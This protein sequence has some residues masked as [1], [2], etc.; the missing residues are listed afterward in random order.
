[1]KNFPDRTIP[2]CDDK[3]TEYEE[4][5]SFSRIVLHSPLWN[6]EDFHPTDIPSRKLALPTFAKYYNGP[7]AT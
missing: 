4:M 3:D 7:H 2:M 1:M 6:W 5:K